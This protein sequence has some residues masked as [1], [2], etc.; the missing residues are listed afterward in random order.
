MSQTLCGAQRGCGALRN[1]IRSEN[2]CGE[3]ELEQVGHPLAI[4]VALTREPE[5]RLDQVTEPFAG[6]DLYTYDRVNR[7]RVEP[8]VPYPG[9]DVGTLTSM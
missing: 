9:L 2:S 4:Y 1:P 6:R 3:C 5:Q 8:V 7:R